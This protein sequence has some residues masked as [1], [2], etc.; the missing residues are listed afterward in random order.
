[1][2]QPFSALLHILSGQLLHTAL[3]VEQAG[4]GDNVLNYQLHLLGPLE[5]IKLNPITIHGKT[6]NFTVNE[7]AALFSV[8]SGQN[9]C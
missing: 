4:S 9:Y 1:M 5:G 3:N 2:F 8:F 7:G 6:Q